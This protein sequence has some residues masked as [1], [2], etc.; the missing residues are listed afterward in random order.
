MKFA[1][2]VRNHINGIINYSDAKISNGVVEGINCQIQ[3]AKRRARGYRNTKN[4]T[5]SLR[6][7]QDYG[8]IASGAEKLFRMNFW[9]NLLAAE[10]LEK[11]IS[12]TNTLKN[13]PS[14]ILERSNEEIESLVDP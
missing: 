6:L 4:L 10:L 7:Y 13:D 5:E 1:K 14:Q 3:L 8:E 9:S 2:T 12:E 11:Q